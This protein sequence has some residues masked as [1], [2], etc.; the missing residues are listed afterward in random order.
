MIVVCKS[1][2]KDKK[3]LKPW[4]KWILMVKNPLI[5]QTMYLVNFEE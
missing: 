3:P 5:N 4:W 1:L 2:S